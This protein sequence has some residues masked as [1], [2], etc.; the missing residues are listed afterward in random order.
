[1]LEGQVADT[2]PEPVA[3]RIAEHDGTLVLDLGTTDGRAV[4]IGPDGWEIVDESPVLFRRT[5][6]TSALPTPQR[7]AA[8]E[9]DGLA[10]L[11][12]LLNVSQSGF[13]LLVAW[14]VAALLPEI[15]HPIL[16]LY[17]EQGTAKSTTG[18]MMVT[19]VDPSPA[20]LRAA[21]RDQRGWQVQAAT[22]WTVMRQRCT[23]VGR[24]RRPLPPGGWHSERVTAWGGGCVGCTRSVGCSPARSYLDRRSMLAA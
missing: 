13:R 22:S 21:P 14:L 20:P 1:V 23:R 17:G 10:R 11:H 19:L 9:A 6:Q 24:D 7:T 8:G 16:S 3:L 15:P 18:R 12:A 2:D 4:V 5:R